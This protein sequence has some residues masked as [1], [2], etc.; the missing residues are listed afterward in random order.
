LRIPA[1]IKILYRQDVTSEQVVKKQQGVEGV[2][3]SE[4]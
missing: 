4:A 1:I 2:L 3:P